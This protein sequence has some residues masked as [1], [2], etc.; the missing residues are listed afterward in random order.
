MRA[1][2]EKWLAAARSEDEVVDLVR[3]YI[4]TW[5]PH[6][7]AQ[8]PLSC[9]PGKIR[10]AE[11]I[12]DVAFRLTKERIEAAGTPAPLLEMEAF[13]AHACA[14]LSA[15]DR[16]STRSLGERDDD[17]SPRAGS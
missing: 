6:E 15:L 10:D 4:A 12:G 11:D 17:G 1:P 5:A 13:F 16:G 3:D 7:L 14:R 2:F 8:V 9:R